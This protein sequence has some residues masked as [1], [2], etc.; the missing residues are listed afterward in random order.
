[1]ASYRESAKGFA[2]RVSGYE[3]ASAIIWLILGV[4]Q[5]LIAIEI[6]FFIVIAVWN[7]ITAISRFKRVDRIRALLPTVPNE[8]EGMAG[9]IIFGLV[10][11]VLGAI[12]GIVGIIIDF[13][14]RDQ[15]LSNRDLFKGNRSISSMAGFENAYQALAKL[16]ELRSQNIITE[17]EFIKEKRRFLQ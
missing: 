11:L 2:S 5:L 10:N 15:V 8:Y 3:K 17:D 13:Y 9:L 14:I 12:L 4:I 16:G 6:P 1:M 7:I